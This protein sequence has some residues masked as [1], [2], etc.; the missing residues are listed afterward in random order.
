MAAR[1]REML[2]RFPN[3]LAVGRLAEFRYYDMDD[4]VERVLNIRW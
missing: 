4:M 2:A 1:Y 3:V